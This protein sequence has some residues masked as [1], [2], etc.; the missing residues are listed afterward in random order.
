M[1]RCNASYDG[2]LDSDSL[3]RDTSSCGHTHL[4]AQNVTLF[5]VSVC[6]YGKDG[7][8]VIVDEGGP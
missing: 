7:D 3:D 4:E 8:E 6:N 1:C 5:D 2:V